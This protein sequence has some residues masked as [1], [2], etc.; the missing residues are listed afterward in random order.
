MGNDLHR[1]PREVQLFHATLFYKGDWEMEY[2]R[3]PRK[4]RSAV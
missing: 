3:G 1:W 4:Q 2:S